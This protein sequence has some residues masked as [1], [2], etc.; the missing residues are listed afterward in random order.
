MRSAV[1]VF[2]LSGAGKSTT[3]AQVLSAAGGLAASVN[4]G[5][6][7]RRQ[8]PDSRVA[9][10][11]RLLGAGEIQSNQE[12]L[13]EAVAVE[14]KAAGPP[15]LLLDGHCVIDNG[16]ELVAVPVDVIDRLELSAVVC[17][18]AQ[19]GEIRERRRLD[20]SRT[21]PDLDE[22]ELSMHQESSLAVCASYSV[23][24]GLPLLVVSAAEYGLI[25]ALV[26]HLA[27]SEK[28]QL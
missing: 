6:L 1:A 12:L 8:R 23:D 24:L 17:L 15:V 14:R 4:A 11:L 7:I 16:E 26:E 13:V 28:C 3:V 25:V 20:S 22:G 18:T 10:D 2:G 9:E 21:R 27:R 19:S 5:E